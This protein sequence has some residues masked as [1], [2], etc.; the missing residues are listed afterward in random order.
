MDVHLKPSMLSDEKK[1]I[2]PL[3]FNSVNNFPGHSVELGFE[4]E[5]FSP[6]G[7][8]A[9]NSI[10][11]TNSSTGT[12]VHSA[13]FPFVISVMSRS[14]TTTSVVP[15]CG[16]ILKQLQAG[17]GKANGKVNIFLVTVEAKTAVKMF[18]CYCCLFYF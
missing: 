13:V 17:T 5:T 9:F 3:K 8:R 18:N 2:S 14:K 10:V 1:I 11:I 12:V 6:A 16:I 4:D 15:Y 7:W